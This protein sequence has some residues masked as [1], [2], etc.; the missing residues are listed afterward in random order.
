MTA[1]SRQT[2]ESRHGI[3]DLSSVS[4]RKKVETPHEALFMHVGIFS[5]RTHVTSKALTR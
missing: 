5:W 3:D 2:K 4:Y 1:T